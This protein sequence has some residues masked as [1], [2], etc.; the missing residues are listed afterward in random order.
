MDQF[1][2]RIK[3][4]F[5][6]KLG[7]EIPDSQVAEIELWFRQLAALIDEWSRDEGFCRRLAAISGTGRAQGV[8]EMRVATHATDNT[9]GHPRGFP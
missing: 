5:E 7:R 8:A 2:T 1:N 3:T 9:R 6:A 4:V